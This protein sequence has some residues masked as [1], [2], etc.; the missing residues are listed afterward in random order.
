MVCLGETNGVWTL[1]RCHWQNSSDLRFQTLKLVINASTITA[2]CDHIPIWM[3]QNIQRR[4]FI[5]H[6]HMICRNSVLCFSK[7]SP[8][9]LNP[10]SAHVSGRRGTEL[11]RFASTRFLPSQDSATEPKLPRFI[12]RQHLQ[13]GSS[14]NRAQQVTITRAQFPSFSHR[15]PPTHRSQHYDSSQDTVNKPK[16]PR[17]IRRQHLQ[18]GSSKNHAQQIISKTRAQLPSFSP[19][20]LPTHR[21]QHYD[22]F[23]DT[24]NEPKIPRF[25]RRQQLQEGSFKNHAQQIAGKV[26]AQSPSLSSRESPTHRSRHYDPSNESPKAN[27]RLLEP[28]VL[29]GRLK[30]LCDSNKVDDAVHMLKN[31]PLDAQNT[32]VWN[33][34][35]WEALKVKRFKLGYQLFIDVSILFFIINQQTDLLV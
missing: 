27:I 12:R 11:T 1:S 13:E 7:Y 21:S 22:P 29:S 26:R 5:T 34:L 23:Q 31:T 18:E 8:F 9:C 25:I 30:N 4:K 3:R 33:T 17:F 2:C 32:Q 24:V 28:H 19:T 35:I 14:K 6:T 10:Y 20:E 16:L 15:V